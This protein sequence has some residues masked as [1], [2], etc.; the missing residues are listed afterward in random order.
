MDVFPG[1]IAGASLKHDGPQE[2]RARLHHVFPGGIAGASLKPGGGWAKR[3][4]EFGFPRRNRRGLIE[5]L[6]LW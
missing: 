3:K 4:R 6:W 2:R 5:A 1:G